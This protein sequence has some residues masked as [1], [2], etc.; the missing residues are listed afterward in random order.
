MASKAKTSP[1]K[2]TKTN[3]AK[4]KKATPPKTV[5]AKAAPVKL[6][7]LTTEERLHLRLYES[8]TVRWAAESHVRGQQRDAYLRKIDPEGKLGKMANEARAV[9]QKSAEAQK[10]YQATVKAVEDR[11]GIVLKDYSF[12]DVTGA[13]HKQA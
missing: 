9:A 5:P 13:L 2:S 12:D 10:Q 4:P 8:E 3:A 1:E 11:L 7:A 6:L